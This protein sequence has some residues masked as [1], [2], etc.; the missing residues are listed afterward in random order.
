MIGLEGRVIKTLTPVG[1]VTVG[2]EYWRTKSVNVNVGV[3]KASWP[4]GNNPW[5]VPWDQASPLPKGSG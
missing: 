2:G 3:G 1:T 4:E 5:Q